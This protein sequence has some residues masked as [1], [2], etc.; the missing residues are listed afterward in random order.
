VQS[1][2]KATP[3]NSNAPVAENAAEGEEVEEQVPAPSVSISGIVSSGS[4]R[5]AIISTSNGTRMISPGMK[6]GDYYVAN[7][8]SDYVTF[9]YGGT[10]DFQNRPG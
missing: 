6:L 1:S 2:D 10:Q 8:G 4:G 7:I 9:G 3:A 5:Q